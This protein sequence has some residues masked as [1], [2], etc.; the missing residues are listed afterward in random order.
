MIGKCSLRRRSRLAQFL[1]LI[2]LHAFTDMSIQTTVATWTDSAKR[3]PIDAILAVALGVLPSACVLA[4]KSTVPLLFLTIVPAGI[5]AWQA[6]W[7]PR[8]IGPLSVVVGLF[9]AWALLASSWSFHPLESFTD[10][11]RTALV[12]VATWLLVELVRERASDEN[13]YR[14]LAT[15]IMVGAILGACIAL[16]EQELNAPLYRLFT[17]NFSGPV[18]DFHTNRGVSLLAFVLWL[19]CAAQP[20]NTSWRVHLMLATLVA[21]AIATSA[22]GSA[23]LALILSACFFVVARLDSIPRRL[24]AG[25]VV[26]IGVVLTPW[27]VQPL[28]DAGLHQ[29]DWLPS[30][31]Q[32][33][34]HIWNFVADRA[35]EHPWFGWGLDSSQSMPNFGVQPFDGEHVIPL[36]PHNGALQIWM[37]LGIVGVALATA[38]LV[39]VVRKLEAAGEDKAPWL[40]AYLVALLVIADSAFGLWQTQWVA[41]IGW[42]AAMVAVVTARPRGTS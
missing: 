26:L 36:H 4:D 19:A 17:G 5:C 8:F 40:G 9:V 7:R 28:F 13:S 2:P 10:G 12:V 29:A 20:K 22:S 15:A 35:F 3:A 1:F 30:S 24:L 34:I 37:E 23:K 33:R 6:G 39:F 16:L 31:S 27:I 38:M 25:I 11:V 42:S 21:A 14:T 32:H 41:S 18:G